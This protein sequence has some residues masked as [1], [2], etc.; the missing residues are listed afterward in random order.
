[1]RL[2]A[3]GAVLAVTGVFGVCASGSAEVHETSL[4]RWPEKG[5]YCG[6]CYSPDH[7]HVAWVLLKDGKG[8]VVVDGKEHTAYEDVAQPL[9]F[10]PDSQ[11]LAYAALRGGKRVAVIDEQEGRPYDEVRDLRFSPDSQRVAYVGRVGGESVLVVDGEEKARSGCEYSGLVLSED[12]QHF[13]CVASRRVEG[14]RIEFALMDGQSG[15]EF[16]RVYDIV[17]APQP[18]QYV[19]A[20]R[21][22]QDRKWYAVVD[23][24]RG[25]AYD[26]VSPVAFS[27]DGRRVAYVATRRDRMVVVLDGDEGAEHDTIRWDTR[28]PPVEFSPDGRRVAYQARVGDYWC[29]VIDGQEGPKFEGVSAVAFSADSRRAAYVGSFWKGE[30]DRASVVI[31]GEQGP[32]YEGADSFLFSPDGRH[33]AY[34]AGRNDSEFVVLDGQEGSEYDKLHSL[35]FSPDGRRLAYAAVRDE[36]QFVVID[37]QEGPR[38]SRLGALHFTPDGRHL[39]HRARADEDSG[40]R[41]VVDGVAQGPEY[42]RLLTGPVMCDDGTIECLALREQLLYRLRCTVA[43]AE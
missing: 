36:Q 5:E 7:L 37:D 40:W 1:M 29:A 14:R 15:P 43:T 18:S 33:V 35:A 20:Y 32:E 31:D 26:Y 39:V 17:F 22:W 9:V 16:D 25:P 27:P 21:A 2:T 41:L 11:R 13:A 28:N 12:G 8:A 34:E 19:L 38:F 3:P 4:G 6:R 10:S 42:E 23:G 24:Q 30:D